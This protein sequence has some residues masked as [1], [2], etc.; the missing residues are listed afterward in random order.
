M[1]EIYDSSIVEEWLAGSGIRDRFD[2]EEMQFSV[3]RY[4]K[5]EIIASPD[6]PVRGLMFIAEGSGGIYGIRKDG[7]LNPVSLVSSPG[8]IGDFEFL[9]AWMTPFYVEA[10]TGMVC[11]VLHTEECRERLFQDPRF[12]CVLLRSIAGKFSMLISIEGVEGTVEDRLLRYMHDF[13]SDGIMNGVE[14]TMYMLRCSRRQ[15]QR[16][17]SCLCE[18]GQIERIGKGRYRLL[19]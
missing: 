4:S 11:I 12:L 2:T 9:E 19:M 3:R 14:K 13:C 18:D 7:S 6:R 17:L 15:L 16:A 8:I 5:G 10:M 1:E